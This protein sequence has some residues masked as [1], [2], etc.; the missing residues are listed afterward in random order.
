MPCETEN[1]QSRLSRVE[2]SLLNAVPITISISE[3][4]RYLREISIFAEKIN[5]GRKYKTESITCE[6]SFWT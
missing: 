1:Q 3:N 4:L 6:N 5:F 2:I